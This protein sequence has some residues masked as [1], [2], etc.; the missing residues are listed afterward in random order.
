MSLYRKYRPQTFSHLVGQQHVSTT[1]SNAVK[2]EK[3]SHAYLFTGPRGT[4]KT[5]SARLLAKAINC[6]DRSVEG[7]PCNK[8]EICVDITDGRL[9]DLI[10]IDAAS[11]RGIDEIRDLREKINF[12]P[13]RAKSKVYIIDEV[14]MLTKEAFNALL[15]TLEEPPEHVYFILAT[16]EVHKIPE[17]I[18]SRCQRFDFRR[19]ED[20]VLLERLK[21][22]ADQEGIKADDAS[23]KLI[24][25]HSEGG[26]RDAIGLLEQLNVN[27]KITIEEA[28]MVLGASGFESL[29]KLF[30]FLQNNESNKAIDEISNLYG[31]GVELGYF[32]KRFLEF[33]RKKMIESVQ[34][35]DSADTKKILDLIENFQSAY[36]Q[37]RYSSIAQLPLEIAIIKSC[38]GTPQVAEKPIVEPVTQSVKEERAH[39]NI[40]ETREESLNLDIL[41][42]KWPAIIKNINNPIVKRSLQMA[43]LVDLQ[44]FSITVAFTTDFYKEK[45]MET[46]NKNEVEI[47]FNKVLGHPYKMIAEVQKIVENVTA[48]DV[49]E[50]FSEESF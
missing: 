47:A 28:C 40:A 26:L 19:I 39:Q 8:C 11:N 5:S 20:S 1:L 29:E 42:Q 10:E 34:K 4:G 49:M 16:T 44:G 33:L 35:N 45:I 15:K 13:T 31:A 32:T 46:E 38:T 22:I 37:F 6:T 27:N 43:K 50:V 23:L 41:R 3:A 7:E 9:I 12:A 25:H 17:T 21:F 36:E 14:H 18:L 24:V 30:A 48:N 2:L